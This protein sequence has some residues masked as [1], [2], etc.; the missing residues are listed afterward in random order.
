MALPKVTPGTYN[1][2]Q[3]AS[4]TQVKYNAA[5][6]IILGQAIGASLQNIG[7]LVGEAVKKNNDFKEET[8][9]NKALLEAS[10]REDFH[11]KTTEHINKVSEQYSIFRNPK[12]ARRMRRKNPE[13]YYAE[14]MRFKNEIDTILAMDKLNIDPDVLA[15]FRES[16]IKLKDKDKFYLANKLS[17][18][19][20][21]L[22][23]VN[24]RT[25]LAYED[26]D[27]KEQNLLLSD[28]VDNIEK[29]T[30]FD[31]AF[32]Y[33]NKDYVTEVNN[34]ANYVKENAV[35]LFMK[36][37]GADVIDGL[38]SL[39]SEA[40]K[41]SLI[42][43][44]QKELLTPLIELYGDDIIEDVLSRE[45][46]NMSVEE[47]NMRV[48]EVLA[49][50]IVAKVPQFAKDPNKMTIDQ[51]LRL[52]SIQLQ[53]RVFNKKVKS[54]KDAL[55]YTEKV[56]G[57]VRKN[58]TSYFDSATGLGVGGYDIDTGILTYYKKDAQ[59]N[60]ITEKI[61]MVKD[62]AARNRVYEEIYKDFVAPGIEEEFRVESIRKFNQL[63]TENPAYVRPSGRPQVEGVE[64][65]D[66]IP[67]SKNQR[68]FDPT[69]Q[70]GGGVNFTEDELD[71]ILK[72]VKNKE[73]VDKLNKMKLN[74]N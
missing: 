46:P 45:N 70:I 65:L 4:P 58:I 26:K 12:E 59:G 29:Y 32:N 22:K 17:N 37:P 66:I 48:R 67:S 30:D 64:T 1:Y 40:A 20:Y 73:I 36:E 47:A 57:D 50:Q 18:S 68:P 34:T 41:Q 6:D 21:Y 25:H 42:S 74:I 61:D 7:Q 56:F 2:G 38:L 9:K 15:Q 71:T 8:Y 39:D 44:R 72:G 54:E 55:D 19:D 35:A 28:V 62:Q 24:G 11:A 31:K 69:E 51:Q 49:E 60:T 14:E 53:E 16:D 63:I 3:Y 52:R 27:G 13:K 10:K 43:G 5:G 23:D 33:G